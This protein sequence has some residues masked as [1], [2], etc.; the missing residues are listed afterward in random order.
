MKKLLATLVIVAVELLALGIQPA[1]A[2]I[3]DDTAA[4]TCGATRP[5]P[6][7]TVDH[8]VPDYLTSTYVEEWCHAYYQGQR[9]AWHAVLVFNGPS[10][11]RSS[12]YQN[13]NTS[14]C[15]EPT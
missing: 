3:Y 2:H 8:A 12:P 15:L 1:S 13:C 5:A 11:F 14:Y 7:F 6:Y 10:I 9:Y 4:W